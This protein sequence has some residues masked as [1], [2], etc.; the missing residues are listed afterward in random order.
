MRRQINSA[1]KFNVD[2]FKV[3]VGTTDK[4]KPDVVFIELETY[5]KPIEEKTSF[6]EY[7]TD[8]DKGTR[9]FI[10]KL[11]NKKNTCENN[12]I[13]VTDVA[14]ERISKGKKSYLDLQIMLKPKDNKTPFKTIAQDIYNE[15][16][17]DIINHVKNELYNNDIE[18]YKTKK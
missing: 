15:Y 13:L 5:I 9:R 7:I 12:F 14:D 8:F 17:I 2:N 11:L 16:A 4:K 18:C 6:T 3:K 1:T 10:N